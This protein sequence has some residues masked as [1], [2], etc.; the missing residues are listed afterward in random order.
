MRTLAYQLCPGSPQYIIE[1]YRHATQLP[2]SYLFIDCG[3]NLPK[4]LRLRSNIFPHEAPYC[5]YLEK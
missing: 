3:A 2:F 4:E 5:V 1:A